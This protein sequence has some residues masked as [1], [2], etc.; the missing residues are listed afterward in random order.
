MFFGTDLYIFNIKAPYTM[1]NPIS[2][3]QG[4]SKQVASVGSK[5]CITT[6][7]K[8]EAILLLNGPSFVRNNKD[9]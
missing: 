4:M 3:N 9:R 2:L 7:N 5:Y 1:A 8:G 6:C